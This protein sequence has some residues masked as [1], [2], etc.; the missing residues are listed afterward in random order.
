MCRHLAY[1]GPPVRLADLLIE[2]PYSLL[3]QSWAPRRQRHG[4]LNADGFGV[5]WYAG[6]V[7]GQPLAGAG[8]PARYRR[9]IPMW[10]DA[11]LA[12]IARAVRSSAVLAAVRSATAGMAHDEGAVAPFAGGP[13]LFSHNGRLADWPDGAAPLAAHLPT[14]DLVTLDAA[15]DSALLW[16]LT[17]SRLEKDGSLARALGA[18]VELAA[19]AA[20]GRLNLLVTDGASIAATAWGDTLC[21]RTGESQVVVAS[22]PYDDEPSWIDVPDRSLL[23]ATPE[24][25]TLTPL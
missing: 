14:A 10:A 25:V 4:R 23:L 8:A 16:A 2:P 3:R 9:A 18:V 6:P 5:G 21:Y 13:W 17:R 15:A 11:N 1:L 24:D 20:S 12:S 22:E 7:D 19:P